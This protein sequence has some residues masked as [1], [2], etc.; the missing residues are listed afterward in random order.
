MQFFMGCVGH[1]RSTL[2]THLDK[3]ENRTTRAGR[4]TDAFGKPSACKVLEFFF[5]PFFF[6]QYT[7][8]LLLEDAKS[9]T[10]L[11]TWKNLKELR[12]I[13]RFPFAILRSTGGA[14]R[15]PCN[16]AM[17]PVRAI[18][19]ASN[20]SQQCLFLNVSASNRNRRWWEPLRSW[21]APNLP[22]DS[23]TARDLQTDSP[24][25][26]PCLSP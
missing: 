7:S 20:V 4:A 10:E 16:G 8:C 17:S 15:L 14:H 18:N 26:C 1:A 11:H 25:P 23:A 9:S 24:A 13:L 3:D 21:Q 19:G 6:Y 22:T 12:R 5:F 2:G